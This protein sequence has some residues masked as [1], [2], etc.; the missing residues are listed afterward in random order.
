M[1]RKSKG[2]GSSLNSSSSNSIRGMM[3]GLKNRWGRFQ[4]PRDG[5]ICK[6]LEAWHWHRHKYHQTEHIN[7]V[8]LDPDEDDDPNA[9][10]RSTSPSSHPHPP[11][12]S[13]PRLLPPEAFAPRRQSEVVFPDDASDLTE[14]DIP[15]L[16]LEEV[17][18]REEKL[19]GG[20]PEVLR[21][22]VMD[23]V[24]SVVDEEEQSG[25]SRHHHVTMTTT[26]SQSLPPET[27]CDAAAA[28]LHG[29]DS[30]GNQESKVTRDSRSMQSPSR[31][32][33]AHR[34][35]NDS[36]GNQRQRHDRSRSHERSLGHPVLPP[37]CPSSGEATTAAAAASLSSAMDLVAVYVLRLLQHRDA[38]SRSAQE[39]LSE[40]K[41][42]FP[43]LGLSREG[44]EGVVAG[45]L[46]GARDQWTNGYNAG[47]KDGAKEVLNAPILRSVPPSPL[48]SP[49]GVATPNCAH[50]PNQVTLLTPGQ[51]SQAK[52][53]DNLAE[54]INFSR[55]SVENLQTSVVQARNC[56]TLHHGNDLNNNNDAVI[57]TEN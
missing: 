27:M 14:P 7:Y 30:H 13:S 35:G 6:S 52:K 3:R 32:T 39:I 11:H 57:M 2:R 38:S 48:Q 20:A 19:P 41:S 17:T 50:N 9:T 15:V 44:L 24:V 56:S 36:H 55:N 21:W 22:E 47:W 28:R 8:E 4:C 46:M 29:N 31:E 49:G 45:A 16:L 43:G 18:S 33:N 34:N 51:R 37:H 10:P 53:E 42:R 40:V 23:E 12:P 26:D 5:S 1:G 25:S 54:K